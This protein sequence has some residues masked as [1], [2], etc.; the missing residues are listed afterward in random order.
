MKK[1]IVTGCNGQLGREINKFY[2]DKRGLEF[3]NTDVDELDIT[4]I[5]A[6]MELVTAE[7]PYAIIN[8]AAYTAVDKAE[9]KPAEDI[10]DV[11]AKDKE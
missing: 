5:E 4:D 2:A 10:V 7:K 9:E 3:I 8:C 1:I 6:V 11:E